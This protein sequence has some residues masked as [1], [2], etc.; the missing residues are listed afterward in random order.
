MRSGYSIHTT[1][2]APPESRSIMEATSGGARILNLV[3]AMA[4][5]PQ[6]LTSF[7][8][9]LSVAGT[10]SLPPLEREI[11][12]MAIGAE[13]PCSHCTAMH[14]ML[15]KKMRAPQALI[16]ALKTGAPLSDPAHTALREF[17]REVIR[18]R[19]AVTDSTHDAFLAAGFT[20]THALEVI[21]LVATITMSAYTSRLIQVP[22]DHSLLALAS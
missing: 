18:N 6:L 3:G 17:T 9:L 4:Q 21:F 5:S 19:G 16:Q 20:A 14:A 12:S 7:F 22:V 11:V 1:E 10:L 2:T 8:Q 13:I 15:L